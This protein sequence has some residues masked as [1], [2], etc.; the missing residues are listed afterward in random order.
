VDT[1]AIRGHTRFLADDLLAGRGTG[2]EGERIAAAYIISQAERL[3]LRPLPGT[4]SFLH[5]VPLRAADIHPES[6]VILQAG[7]DSAI[8]RTAGSSS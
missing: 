4:A 1:L 7:R 6:R 3:G 2:T 5:Q 8:F